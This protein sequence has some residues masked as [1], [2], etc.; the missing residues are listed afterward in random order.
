MAQTNA[1]RVEFFAL[2]IRISPRK[3]MGSIHE[4]NLKNLVTLPLN[5]HVHAVVDR[6]KCLPVSEVNGFP[7]CWKIRAV[8]LWRQFK[9][10][11]KAVAVQV[12]QLCSRK[13]FHLFIYLGN[14]TII[15][16]RIIIN[17][18]NIQ[19][20]GLFMKNLNKYKKIDDSIFVY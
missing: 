10:K 6:Y 18:F 9:I 12:K 20:S 11:S 15:F 4:K 1:V 17:I 2:K 7:N 16:K 5:Y 8:S 19:S 3:R 14:I 13:G